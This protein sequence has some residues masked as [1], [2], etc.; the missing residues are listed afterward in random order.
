VTRFLKLSGRAVSLEHAHVSEA[1]DQHV[2]VMNCIR[3]AQ[4]DLMDFLKSGP[5]DRPTIRPAEGR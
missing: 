5:S 3:V 1:Q 2:R 4:S